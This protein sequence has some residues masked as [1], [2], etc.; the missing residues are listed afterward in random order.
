MSDDQGRVIRVSRRGFL[1]GLTL[2]GGGAL[3]AACGGAPASPAATTAPVATTA[4]AAKPTEA[5]KPAVG[6]TTAPAVGATTAPAVG[7]TAPA[8][9]AAKPA[10]S[11]PREKTLIWGFEGGPVADHANSNPLLPT[12][13]MSYGMHQ[14][15]LESLY[16]LNYETGKMQ[17]W[18]AESHTFN[19]KSDEVTVK[20]RKGA[21]WNDGTPF[22]SKDVVFTINLLKEYAPKLRDAANMKRWVKEIKATDDQT[23]VFSLTEPYPRFI[24]DHFSVHIWGGVRFVPEHIWKGQ[25]PTTFT[26]NDLGKGW[27]VY[28]GPYRMIKTS[29][30]EFIFDRNDDWWGKKTGFA[31]LPQP[32]RIIFVDQGSQERRVALLQNN[33]VDGLPQINAG[34]FQ[35]AQ[36]RNQ[37][38]IG[39]SKNQPWAWIDPCPTRFVFNA[40]KAPWDNPDLRWA[41]NYAINKSQLIKISSEGTLGDE[42]LTRFVFPDYPPLRPYLDKNKDL[43]EKY[44]ILEYSPTKAKQLIEKAGFKLGGDGIY[45]GADGKR[46]QA[47]MVVGSPQE[48]AVLT[49]PQYMAD[50]LKKIGI[51]VALKPMSGAARTEAVFTGDFDFLPYH[52]CGSVVDPW[53]T[54]NNYHPRQYVAPGERLIDGQFNTP[55]W[56]S[57]KSDEYGKVVDQMALLPPNDPKLEPLFRQGL[58][59][60]LAEL[61][62]FPVQQQVRIIPY[63]T[64]VW[65]NVPSADNPY[66]HPPNWWQTS[67]QIVMNLKPAK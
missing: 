54:L 18:L 63:N 55:R 4:P 2:A 31:E 10:A 51:D 50:E 42:A 3:L 39:W 34:P 58:E 41:V 60:W 46:L 5:A 7:A 28:T 36:A 25:D 44:P 24:L 23:V 33:E 37:S 22:T 19:D 21:A 32:Q 48:G 64:T 16:Y 38:V 15:M 67:L 6:A 11:V 29:E 66:I 62:N 47:T 14:V 61:P 8:Q 35:T 1:S 49:G 56:K 30:T 17:P 20:L 26:F 9:A 53:A 65:T 59:I 52:N 40:S 57:A 13:R 45:V 12:Q 27:P 43:F